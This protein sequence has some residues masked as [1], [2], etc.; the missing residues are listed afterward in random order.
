MSGELPP[1]PEAAD[2]LFAAHYL[3]VMRLCLSRLRDAADAE[4]A[5]QEVFRRAVQHAAELRGDPLPW[6][7]TV[8]RHVCA[9]ELRRRSRAAGLS[10]PA[11][12]E[13]A[14]P[15][16]TPEGLV[17]GR[18][19]AM[20]LL[21]RLTPG[22]RRA[23]ATRMGAVARGAA[24]STTRVLLLRAR[25]KARRYMEETQSA[26]GTATVYGTE[27]L[28]H[29]RARLLGRTLIGS[30]RAAV[31]IPAL[32]IVGVVGGPTA[33]PG[34]LPPPA[35]HSS[36]PLADAPWLSG[37]GAA[38]LLGEPAGHS[39]RDLPRG[40][41]GSVTAAGAVLP[42]SIVLPPPSGPTWYTAVPP[43]DDYHQVEPL[44]I[45][46]SPDYATDHT[47]LMV[48]FDHN[49]AGMSL[50]ALVYRSADGGATWSLV[51][52]QEVNGMRVALP[53]TFGS[54]TFY[55]TGRSGVDMTTDG[56]AHFHTVL[57]T[58][59]GYRV[60]AGAGAIALYYAS[61]NA[62]WGVRP[63]GS[64]VLLSLFPDGDQA[65]TTGMRLDTPKGEEILQPVIPA[66]GGATSQPL[67][68]RCDPSC[69]P[70][71][72]LPLDTGGTVIFASP[73]VATDHT[74]YVSAGSELAV[75]HDD[76][77]TFT[78]LMTPHVDAPIAIRGPRGRRIVGVV[79]LEMALGYSDDDG[80]TWHDAAIP[81]STLFYPQTITQLRPGR[82][83]ASMERHDDPGWYYFVCSADGSSWS[84]CSPD[85][86]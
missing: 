5:T 37:P 76:A 42:P 81:Q 46:P 15:Q 30:G 25:E 83:I 4:D 22:E 58:V 80:V 27:A 84:L 63:D 13:P 71:V 75:S 36:P 67:L 73:D 20:E 14:A 72:P 1:P 2:G 8:A 40:L 47:V 12:A 43:Q 17:V 31:V 29:L 64:S 35:A 45:E 16:G 7:L 6:L 44:D 49:C 53:P 9:D 70:A 26:V 65:N 41:A 51:T 61:E 62:L 38:R 59:G 82:L 48:G 19:S 55:V 56:G 74:I 52:A 21:G 85:Q 86:G 39:L 23:V 32:L 3:P 60:L 50:C 69:G 54:G 24:T 68:V 57:P 28:H 34:A 78:K 79:G 10:A 33:G 11:D 18:I 66:T 77:R